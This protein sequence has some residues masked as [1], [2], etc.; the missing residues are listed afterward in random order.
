MDEFKPSNKSTWLFVLLLSS[1][2]IVQL[3]KIG[4]EAVVGSK[5]DNE[6][7]TAMLE[8]ALAEL[9]AQ[10]KQQEMQTNQKVVYVPVPQQ[11]TN[12]ACSPVPHHFAGTI[13]PR[14]ALLRMQQE[15]ME[16]LERVAMAHAHRAKQ[17]QP[18]E[19]KQLTPQQI[20]VAHR[21]LP[22]ARSLDQAF[23]LKS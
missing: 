14:M 16:Q 11:P 13:D 21:Q 12:L 7:T 19:I 1:P 23:E 10:R 20:Q 22:D 9:I 2:V 17:I 4:K 15:M 18:E 6:R 8:A 3:I 5:S